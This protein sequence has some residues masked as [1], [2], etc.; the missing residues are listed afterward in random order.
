ME[1]EKNLEAFKTIIEERK[2]MKD[3]ISICEWCGMTY[4]KGGWTYYKIQVKNLNIE[5]LIENIE[6]GIE[7][8]DN[9]F[10]EHIICSD[11][12]KNLKICKKC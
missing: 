8:K 7:S 4:P 12:H 11:C 5:K 2:K 6:K 3:D 10:E 9:D 1:K